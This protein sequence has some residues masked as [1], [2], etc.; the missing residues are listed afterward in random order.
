[1]TLTEYEEMA[2]DLPKMDIVDLCCGRLMDIIEIE[3]LEGRDMLQFKRTCI[4]ECPIC[5]KK[6]IGD[7]D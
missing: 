2:K 4:V 5:K 1:M 3:P 7:Y 6:W